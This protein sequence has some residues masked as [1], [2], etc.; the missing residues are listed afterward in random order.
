ML[1]EVQI[2]FRLTVNLYPV[3]SI[4]IDKYKL[5]QKSDQTMTESMEIVAGGGVI[6]RQRNQLTEVLLIRRRGV[7]DLPKGK[8]EPEESIVQGALREV[9]EETGCRDLRI[10]FPLGITEHIYLE[11]G[12]NVR[13]KTWWYAIESRIQQLKPQQSEQIDALQWTEI[14]KAVQKVYYENL[15]TVL[16][17]FKEHEIR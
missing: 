14:E 11:N 15:K 8:I 2:A 12:L 3:I 7:W 13:K 16:T 1:K 9:S 10:I 6:Y 4:A 5:E 17:R